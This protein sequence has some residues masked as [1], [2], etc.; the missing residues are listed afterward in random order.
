MNL[1]LITPE[2]YDVDSDPEEAYSAGADNPRV[3]QQI[4]QRIAEVL[5]TMPQ[6]VQDAWKATLARPVD[7]I[8]EGD[9]P[10]LAKTP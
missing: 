9:W 2:L 1:R 4:N 7:P 10:Q 3:V 5:S 8:N 6:Q